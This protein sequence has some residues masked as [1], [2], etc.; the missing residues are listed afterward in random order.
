MRI[1]LTTDVVG[2]VWGYT[3]TLV[4]ELVDRGHDCAVAVLGEPT[5][6]R[7]ATLPEEVEKF[8]RHLRLEWMPGGLEDVGLGTAWLVETAA[9]WGA[10]VVHLNQFAYSAGDYTAPVLVVAHSDVLSWLAEVTGEGAAED[11]SGEWAEYREAVRR[12][13]AAA[14]GIVAP[15]AYQAERVARQYGPWAVRVIHNGIRPPALDADLLPASERPLVL[16]AGRGW[17]EAKGVGLLDRALEIMGDDAPSVHMV[18]PLH[19]PAGERLDVSRLVTHGEVDPTTME[20][21]YTNTRLYVGPSVYEPFG[22]SPL[23]AAGHGCGLLLSGIGSFRELWTGAADFFE[24]L[25]PEVLAES[26]AATLADSGRLDERAGQALER[27]R[28]RYSAARMS[29]EYETLYRELSRLS[30]GIQTATS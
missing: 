17:D 24:P 3:L 26:L 12:G 4:R 9:E 29:E 2:G 21:F 8:Q 15:T 5:E 7:L 23:E 16:V 10:D 6:E 20:R 30:P 27:A 11:R 14:D 28:Q 25:E 13:L 22:L 1:L 18:G 19:G